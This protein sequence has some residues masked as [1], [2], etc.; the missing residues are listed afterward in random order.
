MFWSSVFPRYYLICNVR[1]QINIYLIICVWHLYQNALRNCRYYTKRNSH[2]I[3]IMRVLFIDC[4]LRRTSWAY[5]RCIFTVAAVMRAPS[6]V[7][8][9]EYGTFTSWTCN[10]IQPNLTT[11]GAESGRPWSTYRSWKP[12]LTTNHSRVIY[13]PVVIANSSPDV[14]II[15]FNS[16]F[17]ASRSSNQS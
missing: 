7:P 1:F 9:I 14:I 15:N 5:H 6:I 2:N 12:K 16:S 3:T 8:T 11:S 10:I 4:P 13:T 17:P